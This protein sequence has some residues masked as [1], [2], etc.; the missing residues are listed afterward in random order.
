MKHGVGH[1]L[2]RAAGLAEKNDVHARAAGNVTQ[3][4]HGLER[5]LGI[6]VAQDERGPLRS[7]AAHDQAERYIDDMVSSRSQ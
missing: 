5:A 6:H 2:E 3:A 1:V 7:D 4:A